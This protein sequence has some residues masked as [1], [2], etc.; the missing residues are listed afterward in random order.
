MDLSFRISIPIWLAL[1]LGSVPAAEMPLRGSVAFSDEFDGATPTWELATP[2]S[3]GQILRRER[4]LDPAATVAA[5]VERLEIVCP[6]GESLRLAHSIGASPV[7]DES[8]VT[9]RLRTNRPGVQVAAR[10]VLPRSSRGNGDPPQT[11]VVRGTSDDAPGGWRDLELRDLPQLVARQARLMRTSSEVPIDERG[12]FLDRVILIVPGGPGTTEL[13][14]DKLTVEGIVAK[15]EEAGSPLGPRFP[16]NT[17]GTE[18]DNQPLRYVRISGAQILVDDRPF[19]PRLVQHNGEDFEFLAKCGFNGVLLRE[20]PTYEQLDATAKLGLHIVAPPP[21]QPLE[22]GDASAWNPILT[23]NLGQRLAVTQLDALTA[24]A[25]TLRRSDTLLGRPLLVEPS[26]SLARFS[27][28][29]DVLLIGRR[30]SLHDLQLSDWR[31]DIQSSIRAARPGTPLW[32]RI[33]LDHS[34]ELARQVGVLAPHAA[35]AW[36]APQQI[37]GQAFAA[38]DSGARGICFMSRR[39]LSS[40]DSTNLQMLAACELLNRELQLIEPWLVAGMNTGVANCTDASREALVMQRE[41]VRLVALRRLPGRIGAEETLLQ[42]ASPTITVPGVPESAGAYV[43]TPG[44]MRK[45]MQQRVAGGVRVPLDDV[46]VGAYLVLTDDGAAVTALM[47]SSARGAQRA[48][49]VARY[50]AVEELRQ[51]EQIGG[52]LA[53]S[54]DAQRAA[55]RATEAAKAAIG[56]ADAALATSNPEAAYRHLLAARDPLADL[57][58][59]LLRMPSASPALSSSPLAGS[60]PRLVDQWKLQWALDSLS[61]GENLLYGGDCEE[62]A[63]M[64]GY[65]WTHT[66]YPV[67][68][69]KSSVELTSSDPQQGQR[70]LRMLAAATTGAATTESADS[71]TVWIASPEVPIIPGQTVEIAGWVRVP[72][73]QVC[74]LT[75]TDSLG[76]DELALDV[77]QT[78]AWQAFRMIRT[79]VEANSVQVRFALYGCGEA[80]VDGVM[81]RPV[82]PAPGKPHPRRLPAVPIG[83]RLP[84]RE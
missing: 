36:L 59:Q 68:N 83:Q 66:Q 29:V 10:V 79:A 54:P 42:K 26:D 60:L 58:N 71:A 4:L 23:W 30:P 76:G 44:G 32:L 56:R 69:I 82:L 47:R 67:P 35:D 40:A 21:S 63:A 1:I 48:A 73:H 52:Q 9:V 22:K 62:L 37:A 55:K 17:S 25:Q 5:S 75:I 12:A 8:R 78:P 31:R 57:A 33:D 74:H 41:R 65:G 61:Q 84:S 18:T 27:R 53:Q 39:S 19:F 3:P 34:A 50:L 2:T 72:Q 51:A 38:V 16:K 80:L 81:I 6:P 7:L 46:P 49:Q 15:R 20:T 45:V 70:A 14:I 64:K 77:N 11:L 43:L 24:Q 13:A 28:V